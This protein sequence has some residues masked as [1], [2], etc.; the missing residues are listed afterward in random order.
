MALVLRREETTG[1]G[2]TVW[3]EKDEREKARGPGLISAGKPC[4]PT[5]DL[6]FTAR[7]A[8]TQSAIPTFNNWGPET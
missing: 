7:I 6:A 3:P 2:R 5:H 8:K 4:E 1:D